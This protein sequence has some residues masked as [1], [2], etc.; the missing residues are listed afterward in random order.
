[1]F[2]NR[3]V[4]LAVFILQNHVSVYHKSRIFNALPC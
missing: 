4:A 1:M 3:Q 2:L